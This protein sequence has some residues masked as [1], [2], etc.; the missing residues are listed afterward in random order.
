MAEGNWNVCKAWWL[1]KLGTVILISNRS[2]NTQIF[3]IQWCLFQEQ[4]QGPLLSLC[5]FYQQWLVKLKTTMQIHNGHTFFLGA[6]FP[7]IF[8]ENIFRILGLNS[9]QQSEISRPFSRFII[10][11]DVI[12]FPGL[13]KSIKSHSF[14]CYLLVFH[15]IFMLVFFRGI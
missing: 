11:F 2:F 15:S 3:G 10:D 12:S 14:I 7:G 4:K 1:I 8:F 9:F 6:S 5:L 13:K